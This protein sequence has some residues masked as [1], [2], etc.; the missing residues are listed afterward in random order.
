VNKENEYSVL[1]DNATLEQH[2]LKFKYYSYGETIVKIFSYL[3]IDNV[4]VD[5]DYGHGDTIV[6]Y[7]G[8]ERL[9]ISTWPKSEGEWF[10]GRLEDRIKSYIAEI[11]KQNKDHILHISKNIDELAKQSEYINTSGLNIHQEIKLA[12]S[13]NYLA[14]S[15]L[16]EIDDW[17]QVKSGNMSGWRKR[18]TKNVEKIGELVDF[19]KNPE[20]RVHLHNQQY[21]DLIDK[22][23]SYLFSSIESYPLS[24]EQKKAVISE[25]DRHLLIAAAGSGKTSTIVAKAVYL[26][27]SGQA[28]PED[29]LVLAYNKDAKDELN[30]RFQTLVNKFP[31][32]KS[33]IEAK[34]FHGFGSDII[35][36]VEKKKPSVSVLANSSAVQ[37]ASLFQEITNEL[38]NVNESFARSWIEYLTIFKNPI[39]NLIND[40]KTFDEYRAYLSELGAHWKKSD[41]KLRLV[42]NALDGT[43]VK[44]L[45]ELRIANWLIINGVEFKYER[46]YEIDTADQE[47]RQYYPDFYYPEVDLYHEHFAFNREGQAPSFFYNYKEGVDWKRKLHVK[48]N[49]KLFETFSYQVSEGNIFELLKNNLIKY[50][51]TFRQK[52]FEQLNLLA[53]ETF[54]PKKDFQLFMTF[55]RHFKANNSTFN[56]IREKINQPPDPNRNLKFFEVFKEIYEAYQAMLCTNQEIDFEDQVNRACKYLEGN[57]YNH[58]YNYILVDEFQD[59]SQDRKRMI[60]ALIGQNE[61]AKLFA[62]GDDWQS[63]YRFS[64]ADINIMTHFADHFGVVTESHLTRTY[65]SFQGIVD[66]A[67]EFIQRNPNQI[68]KKVKACNNIDMNQVYIREF[69]SISD[70][71]SQIKTQLLKINKVAVKRNQVVSVFL[72]GRYN[73]LEPIDLIS[74]LSELSNISLSFKTIHTAKG[75]EADYVIILNVEHSIYG[76][77]SQISDDPLLKMVIPNPEKFPHAEERRLMYVAITRA[78]RG[79]YIFSNSKSYSTFSNELK[80]MEGV[81][82]TAKVRRR[83]PCPKCDTGELVKRNGKQGNFMECSNY[84]NCKYT[85]AALERKNPCPYCETGELVKRKS[86]LGPFLGCS[87]YPNCKFLKS[88]CPKCGNDIKVERKWKVGTR[89]A[90]DV[91]SYCTSNTCDYKKEGY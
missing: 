90:Y 34:T 51:V 86:K 65:R 52:T 30:N 88:I 28:N 45:E 50:G 42:L 14:L 78:K 72:L 60:Q 27:E 89:R 47:H 57:E 40:I 38:I 82:L 3:L 29:I 63:I 73:H 46:R 66:V 58:G 15:Q 53:K 77:P 24:D 9:K 80:D 1:K 12:L 56:S 31:C 44:S 59:I 71:L 48:H 91:T 13:S 4:E 39:V 21:H 85:E 69:D 67:S 16:D 6:Y 70:Q 11:I 83:N 18:V 79:V 76:F 19:V 81:S 84:Q 64:G 55:L 26:V 37:M 7:N 8:N 33:A 87:N 74:E 32:Y 25:E 41:N 62:V 68:Q 2:G 17:E 61:T 75:L 22:K 36:V 10:K 20:H 54:N 43:E 23:Y 49:T 5:S 35:S